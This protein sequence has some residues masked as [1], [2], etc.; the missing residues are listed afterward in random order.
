MINLQTLHNLGGKVSIAG[1]P[2]SVA[3]FAGHDR[4]FCVAMLRDQRTRAG[5]TL[6]SRT[7]RIDREI[8]KGLSFSQLKA[9]AVA[10]RTQSFHRASQAATRFH[11]IESA[12]DAPKLVMQSRDENRLSLRKKFH[13]W[14]A[15]LHTGL[16]PLSLPG[17]LRYVSGQW[18]QDGDLFRIQSRHIQSDLELILN[19]ADHVE[20]SERINHSRKE[21]IKI[22]AD[23]SRNQTNSVNRISIFSEKKL[24]DFLCCDLGHGTFLAGYLSGPH[25]VASCSYQ[26]DTFFEQRSSDLF[27][28]AQPPDFIKVKI[29][30]ES[31]LQIGNQLHH[32]Q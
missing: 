5:S 9:I 8:Q 23:F 17:M 6:E 3:R 13:S 1:G 15:N 18:S 20:H 14:R 12:S 11:F 32:R 25:A 22:I 26:W 16:S 28:T 30:Q 19:R 29:D 7:Q 24:S 31:A 10:H 21:K 2:Y 27:I 4:A